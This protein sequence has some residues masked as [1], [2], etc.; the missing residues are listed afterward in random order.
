MKKWRRP[1]GSYILWLVFPLQAY[2]T[3]D[4]PWECS[5][6]TEAA[7]IRC[8][9]AFIEHQ[10][11]TIARLETELRAQQDAVNDLKG[12]VDRQAAATADAQRR[13]TDRLSTSPVVLPA[14][15]PFFY[16]PPYPSVA[17][18]FYFG[19]PWVYGPYW[20]SPYWT[21]RF[22]GPWRRRW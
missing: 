22:Y 18:G 7:Q 5:N 19:R 4:V 8:I 12:Q 21:S 16:T 11:E 3:T 13:L 14:P 17:F 15:Y 1:F 6:Y 2:A 10:R 9:N 20:E